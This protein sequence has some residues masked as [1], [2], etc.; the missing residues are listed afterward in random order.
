MRTARGGWYDGK[1]SQ[2]REVTITCTGEVLQVLGEEVERTARLSEVRID[3][4]LGSARRMIRFPGGE[5]VETN[6]HAFLRDLQRR[7]GTGGFFR[8]VHTWESS[9]SR[10]FLALLLTLLAGFCFVRYAIPPLAT[11]AAFALPAETE[12]YLGR[13]TLQILD[14][15]VLE[16]SKLPEERKKELGRLFHTMTARHPERQGW[17]LEFRS[18]DKIGANAFALPSGIVI[19]TDKLVGLAKSD[20][21]IAG[22]LAH[23]IGHVVR[24]HAL[25]HLLQNSA[26]A[27]I[28]AT[29]AG[30]ITSVSSLTATM[31]TVLIDAKYSRDFE[32]EADDAAVAYLR[33]K[34]VP[35]STYAAILTR[36]GEEHSK[37][38]DGKVKDEPHFGELFND[39]PLMQERVKRVLDMPR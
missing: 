28:V 19:V 26:T 11:R 4:Q 38:K 8:F 23:E 36:L 15:V 30:D 7:Q 9:L 39:H 1:T 17:R 35:V 22:V 33:E 27:L 34:G 20:D 37:G 3:P 12:T 24:R 6:D 10:A 29:V 2:R 32:R 21:E 13:E 25:R 16:P 14:R 5:L 31:P 18:G